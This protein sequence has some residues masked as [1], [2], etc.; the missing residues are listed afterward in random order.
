[1]GHGVEWAVRAVVAVLLLAGC[2]SQPAPTVQTADSAASA[3]LAACPKLSKRS[4]FREMT[5]AE[6]YA[7]V[8]ERAW[9]NAA[10]VIWITP[11][12]VRKPRAAP[13]SSTTA[14]AR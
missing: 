12:K 11:P 8:R 14:C 9:R 3:P 10:T 2:A 4:R 5:W 6:Y 7:D 13:S 1:M